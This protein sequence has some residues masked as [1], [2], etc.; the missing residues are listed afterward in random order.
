MMP[1]VAYTP[2]ILG[3]VGDTGV[4]RHKIEQISRPD[5]SFDLE[6]GSTYKHTNTHIY[7]LASD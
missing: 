1:P 6:T 2:Y 4:H 3:T 7:T 5:M